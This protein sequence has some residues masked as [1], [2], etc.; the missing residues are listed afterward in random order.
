MV[1]MKGKKESPITLP[2][3]EIH[4]NYLI[5]ASNVITEGQEF[6][7]ASCGNRYVA[8]GAPINVLTRLLG[9]RNL[10]T[11]IELCEHCADRL[12]PR[13]E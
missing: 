7:C 5:Y 1:R 9:R 13:T 8:P 3:S 10:P 2:D 11:L 4:G 12:F 6:K